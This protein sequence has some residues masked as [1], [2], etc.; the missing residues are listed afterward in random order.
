MNVNAINNIAFK[1]KFKRNDL[2]DRTITSA[3]DLHSTFCGMERLDNSN[4]LANALLYIKN[5]GQF[6][7][8]EIKEDSETDTGVILMKN[9]EEVISYDDGQKDRCINSAEAIK[10]YVKRD[11]GKDLSKEQTNSQSMA[12][13]LVRVYDYLEKNTNNY[14]AEMDKRYPDPFQVRQ[15]NEEK[16]KY[17]I[18]KN[19]IDTYGERVQDKANREV[20]SKLQHIYDRII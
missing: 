9:D 19:Y 14:F 2:F 12:R 13:R 18:N 3:Q 16:T 20:K 5:D 11:F 10:A 4:E 6:D 8:Y 15:R 7:V 1:S 17:L